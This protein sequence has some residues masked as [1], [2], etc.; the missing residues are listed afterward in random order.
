MCT[1]GLLTFSACAVID[2]DV[3]VLFPVHA[4][5][6]A[7]VAR[8]CVAVQHTMIWNGN[9]APVVG[10]FRYPGPCRCEKFTLVGRGVSTLC[11]IAPQ[12]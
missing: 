12:P 5:Q 7:V 6:R 9:P 10:L 11:I 8:G 3:L 2:G 1:K 4:R